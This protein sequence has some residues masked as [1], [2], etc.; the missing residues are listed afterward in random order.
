MPMKFFLLQRDST[1]GQHKTGQYV[2]DI[3]YQEF[4]HVK[5]G[6]MEAISPTIQNNQ[7]LR[8][9]DATEHESVLGLGPMSSK[10][11]HTNQQNPL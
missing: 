7:F 5:E 2:L 3:R 1:D 11:Q 8:P 9:S 10:N 4:L 6:Q